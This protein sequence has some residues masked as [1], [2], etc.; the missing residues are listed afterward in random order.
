LRP[1]PALFPLFQKRLHATLGATFH[2]PRPASGGILDSVAAVVIG[3]PMLGGIPK[4]APQAFC[5]I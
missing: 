3:L 4:L 2:P 5:A 1:T